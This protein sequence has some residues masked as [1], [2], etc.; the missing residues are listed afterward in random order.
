MA[1]TISSVNT[2]YAFANQ[3][4]MYLIGYT[5]TLPDRYVVE[6]YVEGTAARL[7]KFY[8]T[9]NVVGKAHFD[10]SEVV[11]DRVSVD[12]MRYGF[13]DAVIT[14][15]SKAYTTST[16]GGQK[17]TIKV[18]TYHNGVED[19][20]DASLSCLIVGG[21]G[22]ISQ[23]LPRPVSGLVNYN[24]DS[25]AWFT[26]RIPDENNV[27][28][29][30]MYPREAASMAFMCDSVNFPNGGI[31]ATYT[32]Y[33]G[34][35][36]V[37]TEQ[38]LFFNSTYGAQLPSA[39]DNNRKVTYMG[40][41]TKNITNYIGNPQ[42]PSA[43]DWTHY[44]IV[45]KSAGGGALKSSILRF[46]NVCPPEKHKTYS[47]HWNNTTGGWDSA[48]FSGRAEQTDSVSSKPYR[49]QI[50][51]WNSATYT[52]AVEAREFIPYQIEAKT[53]YVLT[54]IDFSFADI[55]LLK[56]ALRANK[57]YIMVTGQVG[58]QLIPVTIDTSSYVVKEAFSGVFSVS[59][60]VTLAQSIRC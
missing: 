2:T 17:F 4:L 28:H 45:I 27:I 11:K 52:Q 59:L 47:L 38:D 24:A 33:N 26:D 43:Q 57:L 48:H 5:T 16:F 54:S 37:G 39:T 18:G 8:L 35:S 34:T 3:P 9:P 7:A 56:Y 51:D 42:S 32:L 15:G 53:K 40:V 55:E 50:A 6:V 30:N 10:L 14:Y 29:M 58:A 19:L 41:G 20:D 22:Q 13:Q 1:A 21:T 46:H 36:V 25:K 44:E 49:K 23:G 60:T 31:V 12:E